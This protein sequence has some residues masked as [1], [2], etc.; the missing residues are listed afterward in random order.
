MSIKFNTRKLTLNF[1]TSFV[2][3]PFPRVFTVS[4]NGTYPFSRYLLIMQNVFTVNILNNKY[5]VNYDVMI[6]SDARLGFFPVSELLYVVDLLVLT[7]GVQ[8]FA[9]AY[10]PDLRVTQCATQWVLQSGYKADH[11]SK[12]THEVKTAFTP[13]M[14]SYHSVL[15]H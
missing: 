2:F 1:L 4:A 13:H 7:T 11:T 8:H 3:G 12:T 14:T 6:S 10:R 9:I 15:E 5:R